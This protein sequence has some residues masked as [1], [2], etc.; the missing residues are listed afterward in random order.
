MTSKPKPQEEVVNYKHH[1]ED[2]EEDDQLKVKETKAGDD[3]PWPFSISTPEISFQWLVS[4]TF[5]YPQ[6]V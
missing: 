4:L 3:Q 6:V 5:V 2:R 1:D